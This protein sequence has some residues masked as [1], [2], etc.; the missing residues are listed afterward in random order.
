MNIR[1]MASVAKT[2]FIQ[3][4]SKNISI[5][6]LCCVEKN[7]FCKGIKMSEK[8]HLFNQTAMDGYISNC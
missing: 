2:A 3:D 5:V 8:T 6:I 4:P 1:N 7:R